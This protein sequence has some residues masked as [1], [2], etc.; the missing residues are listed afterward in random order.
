MAVEQARWWL[1]SAQRDL[2][3][4][5]GSLEWG[6]TAGSVFWSQQAAEK[7]LRA[8]YL[9][10]KGWFPK[11]HNIRRL[12]EGLET[13]L[14]LSPEERERAYEL[15]QYYSLSRCP[16]ITEGPPEDVIGRETARR[17]LEV[18][19]RVVRAAAKAMGEEA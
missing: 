12:M 11:T 6:D 16:D 10:E 2:E 17:A 4:S 19:E 1:K 3:R 7:V 9:Q 15:T 5:R 18:A 14:E 8:L 13:P